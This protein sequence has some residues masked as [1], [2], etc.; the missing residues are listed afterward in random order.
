MILYLRASLA[1]EVLILKI[2]HS[3]SI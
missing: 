2:F 3:K 1:L